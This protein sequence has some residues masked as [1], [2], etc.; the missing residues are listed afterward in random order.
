MKNIASRRRFLQSTT[1]LAAGMACLGRRG[2]SAEPRPTVAEP[3]RQ[4][5]VIESSDV[6]VC[7]GG[8]AGFAA[9]IAAARTG[10][11]VRL[12]EVH[13][14][15]GGIWTAGL[16]SW[17]LDAGNKTGLMKEIVTDLERRGASKSYRGAVA[18]HPE[19]MKL[20]L[21]DWCDAAKVRVRLHTRVV[22]AK[23]DDSGA[24]THVVTE[25]KSGREAWAAGAFID[26]TGDGDLGALAGCRFDY[27][28]PGTG[29]T[30]P[31]TMLVLLTGLKVDEVARFV[32]GMPQSGAWAKSKDL[33]LAELQKA[34]VQPSYT[35]PTLFYI[36]DNLYCFMANHE[37]GRSGLNAEQI[38]EATRLARV[39][40]HRLVDGLKSLGG[41]WK[42][43]QIVAT[44]EQI[45]VRESRRLHGL[46]TVRTEDLVKGAAQPD[47]VARVTFPVDIHS[48][49]PK[50]TKGIM[51]DGVKAKPY[52]IPYR[53]LIARDVK[54]LL[55]A[56]RCISGDFVAHS[57]Y[58][59]TGNS[60]PMGEAAGAAAALAAK[61][62]RLPQDVSWEELRSALEK[63]SPAKAPS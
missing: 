49:D 22:G 42:D 1:A 19:K 23:V 12:I 39:E 55:F 29:E 35:R 25:S 30:Q 53:A 24:L 9:A 36:H 34:G 63:I 57:S 44:A 47:A 21:D 52:D 5:P 10:A 2:W 4:V 33:M 48:T 27:G 38:S 15:L 37:Y 61:G 59:V 20:L 32:N 62:N 60:V 18:Y 16:L 41:I 58:R 45:G 43:I 51:S 13:G 14:C 46:Y 7:G 8:P 3:A 31:M 54:R 26:A 11:S 50:A 40:V 17:I 28:R 6:V 56:G